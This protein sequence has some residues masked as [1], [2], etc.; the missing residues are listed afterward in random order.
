MLVTETLGFFSDERTAAEVYE[1]ARA[2]YY[3][4]FAPRKAS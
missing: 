1:T 2:I 3:G 4:E